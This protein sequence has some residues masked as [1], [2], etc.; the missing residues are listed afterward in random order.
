MRESLPE[1]LVGLFDVSACG[2]AI[3]SHGQAVLKLDGGWRRRV[4]RIRRLLPC[5]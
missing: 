1:H 3:V 5:Y 4:P 2:L